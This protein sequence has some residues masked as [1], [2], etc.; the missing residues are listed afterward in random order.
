MRNNTVANEKSS[1][2]E[3]LLLLKDGFLDGLEEKCDNLENMLLASS[4]MEKYSDDY[5]E[6]CR[7]VH[8][9][10]GSGG[11][12]GLS[13]ISSICHSFEE[14]LQTDY[15]R[16]RGGWEKYIDFGIMYIDLLRKSVIYAKQGELDFTKIE[17]ELDILKKNTTGNKLSC[18]I[19]ESSNSMLHVLSYMLAELNINA[20]HADNGLS[21][22]SRLMHERFDMLITS[23]T[24]SAFDGIALGC[25]VKAM[26]G[27]N[28]DTRIVL[29]TSENIRDYP[30]QWR[31]DYVLHKNATLSSQLVSI[32]EDV[33]SV[34][35]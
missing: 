33:K 16:L 20:T 28:R 10:K 13:I 19:V 2:S 32:V 23:K 3:M 27:L 29:M 7:I 18:L 14:F 1:V 9:I 17:L 25:A 26:G 8:S 35:Y 30:L 15:L 4:A 6:I 21:A 5:Q 34:C 11:T 12:Y 22:L 31:P 24:L